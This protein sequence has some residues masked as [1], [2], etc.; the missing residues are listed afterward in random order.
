MSEV[1]QKSADKDPL[2][3]PLVDTTVTPLFRVFSL[4]DNSVIL[5]RVLVGVSAK[6]TKT[7]ISDTTTVTLSDTTLDTTTVTLF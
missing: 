3:T 6:L 1:C 5:D 7:D 2:L 4:F